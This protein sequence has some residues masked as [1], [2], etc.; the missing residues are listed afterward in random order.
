MDTAK[1]KN[2]YIASFDPREY[3]DECFA[4]PD[5]EYRFSVQFMVNALRNLPSDLLAL[6]FGGG[7][8]LPPGLVKYTLAIT[9]RPAWMKSGAG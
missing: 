1:S 8:S 5:A 2:E 9:Y 4:E 3:L 6:E 7:P